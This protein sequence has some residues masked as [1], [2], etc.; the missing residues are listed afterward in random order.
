MVNTADPKVST[1]YTSEYKKNPK[2]KKKPLKTEHTW[3]KRCHSKAIHNHRKKYLHYL[4]NSC[5]KEFIANAL[6]KLFSYV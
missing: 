3:V 2:N 5:N 4:E 6:Y 1:I